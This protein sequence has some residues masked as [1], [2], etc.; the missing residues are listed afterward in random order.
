MGWFCLPSTCPIFYGH[1]K[2]K[3]NLNTRSKHG[4]LCH[5]KKQNVIFLTMKFATNMSLTFVFILNMPLDSSRADFSH[6]KTFGWT[7]GMSRPTRSPA[8]GLPHMFGSMPLLW[9]VVSKG[10]LDWWRIPRW[11]F[12]DFTYHSN[13]QVMTS[14]KP[15]FISLYSY[16]FSTSNLISSSTLLILCSYLC[17]FPLS[18][19]LAV[20]FL[21]TITYYWLYILFLC[22]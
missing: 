14:W 16:H 21:I 3:L 1:C 2:Y 9:I 13:F 7:F 22:L 20:P 18:I 4:L 5:I 10:D 12:S 15:L 8:T 6:W 17:S 19:Y 11:V